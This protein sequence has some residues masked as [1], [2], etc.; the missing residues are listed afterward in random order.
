MY[1]A[2]ILSRIGTVHTSHL[3]KMQHS[4]FSDLNELVAFVALAD[5]GSFAAAGRQ[6]GRDPTAV[7]RRLTAMEE[8]MG[9]RLAERSTR[10]VALTEA[11]QTYLDRIRPLLHELQAAGGEA[12]AFAGGEARGHLRVALP[13]NFGRLWLT[14]LI[15]DFLHAHPRVTIEVDTSN[16]FVDLIGER[17]DLAIR[18]GELPD[19]RL[20]ARKVADRRRL[21]CASPAFL[22]R[23]RDIRSPQDLGRAPCLCYTGRRDPYR[24]NFVGPGKEKTGVTVAGPLAS[25]DGELLVEAAVRGLGVLYTSDWY[26]SR[27]LANGGL[28]ELFPE[29][30]LLDPGAVYVVT[31][32]AAGTPSKTRAFSNW[33]AE[34]LSSPPWAIARG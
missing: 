24:W 19:S 21:V 34:K 13:G 33:I 8:R 31:P 7:S 30:S 1:I 9:V 29:W 28:V 18:L 11:G 12:V 26:A 2:A 32:A 5:T 14:P 17:F 23:H 27:E 6:L 15:V 16:R 3:R 22:E 25:D 20:V 4:L 10:K